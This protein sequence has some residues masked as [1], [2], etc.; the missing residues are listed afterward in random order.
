MPTDEVGLALNSLQRTRGA[1]GCRGSW[2][3]LHLGSNPGSSSMLRKESVGYCQRCDTWGPSCPNR[4]C[5][6]A[7]KQAPAGLEMLAWGRGDWPCHTHSS[8][9]LQ[10]RWRGGAPCS[11]SQHHPFLCLPTIAATSPPGMRSDCHQPLDLSCRLSGE[12]RHEC[13]IV[14]GHSECRDP[15]PSKKRAEVRYPLPWA[16]LSPIPSKTQ[17]RSPVNPPSTLLPNGQARL[18]VIP[19]E[20]I[21]RALCPTRR[22]YAQITDCLI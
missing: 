1:G 8:G 13:P 5:S 15:A 6:Q 4:S 9:L 12:N 19:D 3:G 11:R 14:Q 21:A 10:T 16:L 18:L 17:F 22:K 7:L 2:G 20:A